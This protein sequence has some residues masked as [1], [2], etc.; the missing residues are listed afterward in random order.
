MSS[1]GHRHRNPDKKALPVD[2]SC[3]LFLVLLAHLLVPQV[4]RDC[5]G[6]SRAWSTSDVL[7]VDQSSL[8][9]PFL[10]QEGLTRDHSLDCR[11]R[12][13]MGDETSHPLVRLKVLRDGRS[14]EMGDTAVPSD[15]SF[16]DLRHL[17]NLGQKE[18]N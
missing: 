8:W 6:S 12:S 13:W 3:S 9:E 10:P 4:H 14:L 5:T 18:E 7:A 15:P 17:L 2:R 16:L 11:N 1:V